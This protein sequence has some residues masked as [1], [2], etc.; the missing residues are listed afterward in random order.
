MPSSDW[1]LSDF[2]RV[3]GLAT[4]IKDPCRRAELDDAGLMRML[5]PEQIERKVTPRGLRREVGQ[6]RN[7]REMAMLYGGIDSKQVTDRAA[8]PSGAMGAIQRIMSNDVACKNVEAATSLVRQ[9]SDG[10]SPTSSPM[11]FLVAH[12]KGIWR[13]AR[14]RRAHL[15][16]MIL[17]RNDAPDSAEVE[18]TFKLLAA[19]VH[20]AKDQ[21]GIDTS[22]ETYSC[23]RDI[24]KSAR[25]PAIQCFHPSLRAR[26]GDVLAKKARV[27]VRV[28]TILS[29]SERR[30]RKARPF[31]RRDFL[32]LCGL[33]GLGLAVPFRPS[34][35]REKAKDEP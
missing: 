13:S 16:E 22:R 27:S 11:W 30:H 10:S 19:I 15:H 25:R 32:K 21:K 34:L 18:R 7:E 14:P 9:K 2:Y 23:R 35:A 1:I 26:S 6:A 24:P 33:A 8:D 17:G 5:S 20:D 12:R 28:N 3:D 29:R 4:S 31:M